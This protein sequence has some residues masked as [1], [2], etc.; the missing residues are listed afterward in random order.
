MN[1]NEHSI[2]LNKL[3]AQ[4][5]L[6]SRR[7]ADEWIAAGRVSIDGIVCKELGATVDPEKQT[8]RVD[9]KILKEK[10]ASLYL[11]LNK[12]A[13]VMTTK[14]DPQGRCTVMEFLSKEHLR[15][16]VFPVGR[17]DYESEGLIIFTNDGDWSQKL[18]HPSHLVWK[19]YE[20]QTDEVLTSGKKDRL[21]KGVKVDRKK[22]LPAKVYQKKE[23]KEKNIFILAIREGRNRQVRK[24][25]ESVGLKVKKLRRL[26][27][28]PIHLGSLPLGQYRKLTKEEI[29]KVFHFS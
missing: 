14:H 8:I 11:A 27:V 22:T 26:S 16:G 12:P 24:M 20:V 5:G 23:Q 6:C 18:L 4:H 28:G 21:K 9:G 15:A 3:L 13:A 19:T 10:P 29:Q 7:K 17:L 2:R 25:C 1:K